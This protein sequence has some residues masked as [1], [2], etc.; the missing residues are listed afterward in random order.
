MI[1][2]SE[3]ARALSADDA[4]VF[5]VRS[6]GYYDAKAMRIQGSQRLDPNA[7]HQDQAELPKDRPVYLYCTCVR[8]ATSA[9]VARELMDQGVQVAVI[10]GGLRKWRKGGLPVEQV[11]KNEVALMPS[12]I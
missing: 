10:K 11:P 12:F 3:A 4:V 9:R 7:L 1:E 8:E 5:D 2:P 6:H